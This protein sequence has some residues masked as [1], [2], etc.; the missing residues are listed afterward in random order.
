[1]LL[2]SYKDSA[3]PPLPS[4]GRAG[5]VIDAY[6]TISIANCKG[7]ASYCVCGL[8][9][10]LPW[11]I[12]RRPGRPSAVPILCILFFSVQLYSRAHKCAAPWALHAAGAQPRSFC[13]SKCDEGIPCYEHAQAIGCVDESQGQR[14]SPGPRTQ[15][16]YP[17]SSVSSISCFA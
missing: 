11:N 13:V 3:R 12:N 7:P 17:F 16:M 2:L 6:I 14:G 8:V 4:K 5:D 10:G 1:M 15:L 9:D